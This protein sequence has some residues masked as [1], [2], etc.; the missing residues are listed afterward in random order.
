M[1][2]SV[3][4]PEIPDAAPVAP[5]RRR[6]SC[7][8]LSRASR[9]AAVLLL[10]TWIGPVTFAQNETWR[11]LRPLG[12]PA[13]AAAY[14]RLIPAG[15]ALVLE[16]GT[17]L[18]LRLRDGSRVKGRFLGRALLDSAAYASRFAA[19][20]NGTGFVPFTLGETLSVALLDGREWTAPF[21]GYGERALLLQRP[22]SPE[23]TRVPFEFARNVA[24]A[25]GESVELRELARAFRSGRLPS[26]EAIVLEALTPV[27]TEAE[28]WA[29]ALRVPSQDVS[30][31]TV[32]VKEGISAGGI[33]VLSALT[34]VVLIAVIAS[35]Y[36]GPSTSGCESMDVPPMWLLSARLTTRPFDTE[37]GCFAGDPP[38][39]P[40]TWPAEG[41]GAFAALADTARAGV[42]AR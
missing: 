8:R 12:A 19:H 27:G 36:H 39:L 31:A 6:R 13:P 2:A 22:E 40:G 5:A 1:N 38:A 32:E 29:A 16:P 41:G 11:W 9:F 28:R 23:P 18:T 20:A 30:E 3:R 37:R 10:A 17:T 21:A 34:A 14:P 25:N 4:S 7:W 26:A 42:P 35:S 15:E 24:R 33:V